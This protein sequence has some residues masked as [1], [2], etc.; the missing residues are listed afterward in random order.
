MYKYLDNC[1]SP[2][3]KRLLRNWICHPL[4]DVVTINKRLDIVEEFKANSEIMQIT[5]QY[6]HKLPDLERLL[7]RI[8][9]SVQSSASV[10]PA[11]LGKKVLKQRVSINH[12]F[13]EQCLPGLSIMGLASI[14]ICL[15]N[16]YISLNSLHCRL[17][18]LGKL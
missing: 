9:S 16:D 18:H 11:L 13:S 2:T 12:M 17:K 10:L 15:V 4:K 7:G 8:K 3:G 6:L 5:G 1:V 14:A